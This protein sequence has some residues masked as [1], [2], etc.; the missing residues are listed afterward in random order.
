[1][2]DHAV[3]LDARAGEQ[4]DARRRDRG[5]LRHAGPAAAGG[6]RR[7]GAARGGSAE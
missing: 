7:A 1:V 6:E 2:V 3:G 4:R 5:E